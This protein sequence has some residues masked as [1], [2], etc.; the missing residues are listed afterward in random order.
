M[1]IDT[2]LDG[3]NIISRKHHYESYVNCD[4]LVFHRNGTLLTIP[5]EFHGDNV[6]I[7]LYARTTSGDGSGDRTDM[8]DVFSTLPALF[9][10][11]H[12]V[13]ISS[14]LFDLE[15]PLGQG[16][17]GCISVTELYAR[18]ITFSQPFK[19]GVFPLSNATIK[20]IDRILEAVTS[21]EFSLYHFVECN[22]DVEAKS[23]YN[24]LGLHV[25]AVSIAKSLGENIKSELISYNKRLNPNW[26]YFRCLSKNLSV[27]HA[28]KM[29]YMFRH[30]INDKSQVKSYSSDGF[31]FYVTGETFNAFRSASVDNALSVFKLLGEKLEKILYIPLENKLVAVGEVNI[32]FLD[33]DCGT[34]VFNQGKHAVIHR[35][36]WEQDVLFNGRAY[37]WAK[38]IDGERFEEFTRDLLRRRMGV[39]KVSQTSITNEPDSNADLICIWDVSD[40]SDMPQSD[41]RGPVARRKIVVQ[42]K[43]WARNIGKNDVPS[44]R[45]TLDRFEADGMLVVSSRS[46]ARSLFDHFEV[47]RKKG[48]WV[49][50]WDRADLENML[51]ENPD[52]MSN[53]PDVVLYDE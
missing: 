16:E 52:L 25:W 42:C 21:Y 48:I 37:V 39:V 8:N 44:I 20:T 49:D 50:Y 53:Y 3:L 24:D 27:I 45:D 30:L 28:P 11:I 33:C 51:D 22:H 12:N 29:A 35:R 41:D 18:Y 7:Y 4:R 1:K 23:I 17:N 32:V 19:G 14:K 31:E 26:Y 47:L 43:A 46:I 15:H 10:R 13:N 5:I 6:G 40:L 2:F 34:Q 38:K 36:K 9:L